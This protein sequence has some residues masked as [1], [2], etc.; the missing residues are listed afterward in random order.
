MYTTEGLATALTKV[1]VKR[2]KKYLASQNASDR[3]SAIRG[4]HR[5]MSQHPGVRAVYNNSTYTLETLLKVVY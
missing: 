2:I 3:D 5:Y 1:H 4:I